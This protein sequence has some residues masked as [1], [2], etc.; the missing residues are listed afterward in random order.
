MK[1]NKANMRPRKTKCA[2]D[3]D[4]ELLLLIRDQSVNSRIMATEWYSFGRASLVD[5]ANPDW[6]SESLMFVDGAV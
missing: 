5:L 2:E 4:K 1:L 3:K 6:R